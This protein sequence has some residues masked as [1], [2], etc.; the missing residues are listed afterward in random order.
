MD[1][2]GSPRSF[3]ASGSGVVL[4]LSSNA[5]NTVGRWAAVKYPDVAGWGDVVARY[6]HLDQIFVR[7]GQTVSL[8]TL[9]GR[10][11]STGTYSTGAHLH[12]ELD[13]DAAYWNYTPTLSSANG[14]LAPGVRGQKDTTL[15]P[16]YVFKLKYSAPERQSAVFPSVGWY[17]GP[18]PLVS[19]R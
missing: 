9:I 10:Y 7:A 2:T 12:V 16:A 11:G 18:N 13:S 17:S 1:I 4:G 6:F 5:A 8:N 19:W 15:N 3:Y 14:G